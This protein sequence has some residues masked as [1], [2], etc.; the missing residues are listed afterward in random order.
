MSRI[1]AKQIS[2]VLGANLWP[3]VKE[4]IE[5]KKSEEYVETSASLDPIKIDGNLHWI[6]LEKK[7]VYDEEGLNKIGVMHNGQLIKTQELKN[8]FQSLMN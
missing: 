7:V 4:K 1:T 5:E 8:L 2:H 3:I 6:D